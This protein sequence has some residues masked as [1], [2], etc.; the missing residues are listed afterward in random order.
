MRGLRWLGV[1][2]GVVE[3]PSNGFKGAFGGFGW[4]GLWGVLLVPTPNCESRC[5]TCSMSSPGG[6]LQL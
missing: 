5:E 4:F 6:V 3:T 2:G 1:C